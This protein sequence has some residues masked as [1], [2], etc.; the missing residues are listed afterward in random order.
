M[1]EAIIQGVSLHYEIHG[2]GFPLILCHE[3][4]G[5]SRS[6]KYQAGFFEQYYRVITYDARGYPPSTVPAGVSSY[7]QEQAVEDLGGVLDHLGFM[8]AHVGGF[9]MGGSVALNFALQYPER[10]RSLMIAGVGTGSANPDLFRQRSIEFARRLETEGIATMAD[11][12][13]GP[14]RVQ[15]LRKS[16]KRWQEFAD[17]L[18][19]HSS[20]G[21]AMTL[22]GV[23]GRRPSIFE[24]EPKMRAFHAPT[25][26]VVGDEDDPCLEPSLFMKRCICSSGLV[27]LPQTGHTV[28]LE[29]PD[30]FNRIIF[31]FLRAAE[32]GHW[33][34]RESGVPT[35]A[36]VT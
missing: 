7:S 21:L 27:V 10:V 14:Q 31:D 17:Q 11:Y 36:L 12:P 25:L 30:V 29:D 24:L 20:L 8:Q 15:L 3:F 9:S 2:E 28:N 13:R 18:S 1:P 19:Q 23:L 33:V 35:A 6:W 32:A 26:I 4:A 5:D 22:R 34:R 16:P